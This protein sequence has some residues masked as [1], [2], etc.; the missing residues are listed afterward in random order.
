M[1]TTILT[2]VDVLP[3]E[4][5]NLRAYEGEAAS[6]ELEIKTSRDNPL[7]IH[8]VETDNPKLAYTL[9]PPAGTPV[10]KDQSYKLKLE[11]AADMLTGTFGGILKLSTNVPEQP[12][13][14][15]NY[16]VNIQKLITV[17]PPQ[18]VMN[19]S[20]RPY[21]VQPQAPVDALAEASASAA[22]VGALEEGRD[23]PVSDIRNDFA[24][25]RFPDGKLGWV[26]LKKVK[27]FYG[28]TQNSIWVTKHQRPGTPPTAG[29]PTPSENA[30]DFQVKGAVSDLAF[31]KLTVEPKQPG[32]FMTTI[33]YEGPMEEKTFQG[34][35][36]LKTNDAREPEI[37]VPV[38]ITVGQLDRERAL[39][40]PVDRP[41]MRQI[42]K[43]QPVQPIRPVA[44]PGDA[45]EQIHAL[46]A[47]WTHPLWLGSSGGGSEMVAPPPGPGPALQRIPVL[48]GGVDAADAVLVSSF[49]PVFPARAVLPAHVLFFRPVLSRL[50]GRILAR[51]GSIIKIA[52]LKRSCEYQ[53]LIIISKSFN[54]S[55]IQIQDPEDPLAFPLQT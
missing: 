3:Q 7:V 45:S 32:A 44:K 38:Q 26:E 33:L 53:L 13:V 49:L 12:L 17:S 40:P 14:N 37:I 34:K 28:G 51:R 23:Y 46:F 11:T 19:I 36:T 52:R 30:P 31:L 5:A 25:I 21:K 47:P 41:E 27:P 55:D 6:Q 16:S 43:L 15:I 9:T 35:V 50:K 20:L 10:P 2:Y 39:R 24:Q 29:A 42:Q 8:K 48:C 22:P 54:I 4:N 1:K 18:V